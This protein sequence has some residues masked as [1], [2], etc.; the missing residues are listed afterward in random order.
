MVNKVTFEGFRQGD[1]PPGSAPA[2]S[3]H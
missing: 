1:R 3:S 2:L